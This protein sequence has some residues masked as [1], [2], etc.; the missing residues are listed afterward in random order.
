VAA[1]G[2]VEVDDE[3]LRL[4]LVTVLMREQVVV[5][6]GGEVGKFE[7][8]DELRIAFFY[9]LFDELINNRIGL[10][11][12]RTSDNDGRT[13]GI[14]DIDPTVVPFF[15]VIETGGQIDGILVLDQAGLL[16]KAFVLV[17]EYIVEQVVLQQAADPDTRRQQA[18]VADG[19]GED[20][21]RSADYKRHGQFQ[22]PPVEKEEHGADGQDCPDM[23]PFNLFFLDT[24]GSDT[25]EGKEH[26]TKELGVER[27][28]KKPGGAV[29]VQ[30]YLVHGSDID[31]PFFHGG[32]T[33][34]I[35][36]YYYKQDA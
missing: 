35:D 30:E 18:E 15:L 28:G 32:V 12:A 25:R 10:P 6:D 5:G 17:V 11:A 27:I 7:V 33:V 9:L 1:A 8:V 23:H 29:E 36:I 19:K 34:P 13:L 16:H 20:I 3:E 26:H 4:D 31:A 22:Q 14:D 24:F 21:E 2:V